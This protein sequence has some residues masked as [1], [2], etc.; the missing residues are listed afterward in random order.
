M[1][2]KFLF[3]CN[4]PESPWA[5]VLGKAL[6]PMGSLDL[7]QDKDV[8]ARIQKENYRVLIIDSTTLTNVPHLV[9]FLR[10][11]K[12]TVPIVVA[13]SS[14][15][16]DRAREVFLAGASDYVHK[17]LDEDAIRATVREVIARSEV[18]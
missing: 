11:E 7:A 18:S 10:E 1:M 6:A 8:L 3:I 14:P 12:P 16:W 2:K 17:S 9:A 15:T 5:A 13:T 4:Q